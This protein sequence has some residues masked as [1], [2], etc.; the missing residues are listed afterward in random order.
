M[1][2]VEFNAN[3]RRDYHDMKSGKLRICDECGNE[4]G[5]VKNGMSGEIQR[6]LCMACVPDSMLHP[7]RFGPEEQP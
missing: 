7:N 2:D 4:E 6:W 5:I 1:N 3:V